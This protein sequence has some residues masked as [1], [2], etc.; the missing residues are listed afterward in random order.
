MGISTLCKTFNLSGLISFAT[1][2]SLG[3]CVLL[4]KRDPSR[5]SLCGGHVCTEAASNVL[6]VRQELDLE[7]K[8]AWVLCLV[9]PLTRSSIL[10]GVT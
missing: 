1:F 4:H 6:M 9:L 5:P 2:C 3:L 8:V 10:S 7:V